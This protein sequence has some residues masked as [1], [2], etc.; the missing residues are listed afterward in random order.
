M[1][2]ICGLLIE[3]YGI[4]IWYILV[5]AWNASGLLIELYG[6]EIYFGAKAAKSPATFNR[7]IWNWNLE[8]IRNG[9]KPDDF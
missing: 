7:T 6:I 1:R 3:L 9:D 5:W 8:T 2:V 4:E